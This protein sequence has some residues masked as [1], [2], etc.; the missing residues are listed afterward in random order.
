M[1]NSQV[2]T[3]SVKKNE[4]APSFMVPLF[5]LPLLLYQIKLGW[6]LGNR[7]MQITHIGR[8]S[9]KVRKTILV[10]LGFD[11]QTQELLAVSAWK[12]SDWY[13]NIQ[14]KPAM[15]VES[16]RVHYVPQQR[17]L[18][19]EE[20]ATAFVGYCRQNPIF[21]RIVCRIPGWKWNSTYEEF[22][23]LARTLRGVAFRP[24]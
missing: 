3:V 10:V 12:G 17:T 1:S 15:E 5:K 21:S 23:E 2:Q 20:I 9:G 18:S 22:L 19:P 7:F 6:L 13:Y 4:K 24:Q 8:R 14:A 11:P 16:G